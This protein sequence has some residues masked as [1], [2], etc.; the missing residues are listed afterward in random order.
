M[1]HQESS[2]FS[3]FSVIY[4]S[5]R[6]IHI[7]NAICTCG[8]VLSWLHLKEISVHMAAM[9]QATYMGAAVLAHVARSGRSDAA[10]K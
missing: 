2:Y 3:H 5:V 1:D 9:L 6:W 8:L 4:C 7:I 10:L